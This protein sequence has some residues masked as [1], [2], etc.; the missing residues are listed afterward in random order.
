M[1]NVQNYRITP[2]RISFQANEETGD[3][4]EK[5]V[6]KPY[7][8]HAGIKTG[9]VYGGLEAIGG[10]FLGYPLYAL[11]IIPVALLCGN[12][13]DNKINN[14]NAEL[15]KKINTQ[16]KKEII[17]QNP[18]VE[19]TRNGNLYNKPNIGKKTGAILGAIALPVLNII[20]KGKHTNALGL[21]ISPIEGALGGL[22]LGAITDACASKGAQKEAD[23]QAFRANV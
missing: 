19:S 9:A 11:A 2:Q 8:T 3:T 21:I 14:Q 6:N 22:L 23:K 12:Y 15:S 7:K 10:L 18:N 13:V 17:E 4:Q 5:T 20:Q 16:D 1:L